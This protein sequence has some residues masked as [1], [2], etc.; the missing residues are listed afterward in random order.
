MTLIADA[1]ALQA[2]AAGAAH[3]AGTGGGCL[4]LNVHDGRTRDD[5]GYLHAVCGDAEER[6]H[7]AHLASVAGGEV[8]PWQAHS[9]YIVYSI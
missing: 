3:D 5:L 2:V 6:G 8:R 7:V 1:F 9:K 4:D